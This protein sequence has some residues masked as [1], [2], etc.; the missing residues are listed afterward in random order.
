MVLWMNRITMTDEA[1]SLAYAGKFPQ[2]DFT[3]I[4]KDGR[5][6]TKRMKLDDAIRLAE[7]RR[8]D[9]RYRNFEFHIG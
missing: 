4:R 5:E 3:Y 9:G 7:A 6:T 2:V 8:E 1:A